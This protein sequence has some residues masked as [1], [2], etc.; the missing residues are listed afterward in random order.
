MTA[1]QESKLLASARRAAGMAYAPYSGFRVGAAVL[2]ENGRI[3]AGSNVENASYGLTVCAER[4][5][6]G[7]MVSAGGKKIVAL[8]VFTNTEKLTPPCGAC[9]QVI[10]E[11]TS[12]GSDA[13]D[14]LIILANRR[15]SKQVHLSRL[16]PQPFRPS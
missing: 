11:F 7:R 1:E 10:A 13:N 9:R 15:R 8:L 6:V 2:D 14:P 4:N 12:S 3:H 16:L 5:A